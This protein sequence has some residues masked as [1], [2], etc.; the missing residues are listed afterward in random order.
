MQVINPSSLLQHLKESAEL[1]TLVRDFVLTYPN[2][3]F[4]SAVWLK[5]GTIRL[6]EGLKNASDLRRPGLYFLD[7]L[8]HETPY[9][10]AVTILA[11]SS[12][13]LVT[14]SDLNAYLVTQD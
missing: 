4:T 5:N 6:N 14:K 9:P 12:L 3:V 2:Q 11:G 1:H 10:H 7:E 13:W 8:A